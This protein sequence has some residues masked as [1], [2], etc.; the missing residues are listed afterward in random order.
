[1]DSS[2]PTY[3][4]YAQKSSEDV[5]YDVFQHQAM[6]KHIGDVGGAVISEVTA[7]SQAAAVGFSKVGSQICASSASTRDVIDRASVSSANNASINAL[8]SADRDRDIQVTSERTS[9]KILQTL[10]RNAGDSRLT[11]AV[12]DAANRQATS[13][14]SRD[15]IMT[16]DK[17]AQAVLVAVER[18]GS[19]NAAAI[20]AA[21]YQS[22][23]LAN[24][25]SAMH[26]AAL[27]GVSE[28]LSSQ[29]AGQYSSILL[30]QQKAKECLAYQMSDAKYEALKNKEALSAQLAASSCDSKFEAMKNSQMLSSQLAECCCE[31][32]TKV[33]DVSGKV[34]DTLRT[35]DNQRVRDA[36]TVANSEISL[37]KALDHDRHHRRR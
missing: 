28:K 29:A 22:Q 34:D 14:L 20:A 9:A 35:L 1:M 7:G 32:K 3:M 33:G 4:P 10:E 26:Q 19:I 11:S 12:L 21:S 24:S 37:Y 25:T 30:E 8:S 36:L 15:I 13:D 6:D 5:H 23:A 27:C 2:A 17:D 16:T 31:I 18:N